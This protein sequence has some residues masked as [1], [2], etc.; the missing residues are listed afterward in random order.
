MSFFGMICVL[1]LCGT[2]LAAAMMVLVSLPNSPIKDLL[3]QV[4]GWLI[5]ILCAIYAI[6]PID[7]VPDILFPIGIVDDIGIAIAGV[8]SAMAAWNA[9]KRRAA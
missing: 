4:V 3:V 6:S 2:A 9:G 5:A 7:I 8:S 1:A